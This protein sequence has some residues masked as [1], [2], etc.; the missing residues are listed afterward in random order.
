VECGAL[1]PLFDKVFAN[2][3]NCSSTLIRALLVPMPKP[4]MPWPHAPTHQL[5]DLGTYFVTA[6]TYLKAHHFHTPQRLDVLHRELLSV[7]TDFSWGLEAWAVFS[8]HYHFVAHSRA[9]SENAS[10]LSHLLR[11]LH[12]RTAAWVNRLDQQ[13]DRK[14]WHNFWE[15]KLTY[16]K[17][18][19]A[20]LNYVHQNAVKHRLVP[21]AN[22]YQW[23]SARWFEEIA[24][25]AMVR[26]IYRF[27][28]DKLS[29]RDDFAPI[30]K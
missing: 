3:K 24:S 18:Y 6:C 21:V 26:S 15:T 28:I 19:L 25:P 30:V 7:T 10:S 20:R 29:V 4:A 14:V 23:C 16:Q 8:N 11:V 12:A 22:R 27:K 2:S 9:N 5:S 13:P 17:S 1:A